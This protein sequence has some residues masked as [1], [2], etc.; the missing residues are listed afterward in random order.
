MS[1]VQFFGARARVSVT[2]AIVALASHPAVLFAE[3]HAHHEPDAGDLLFPAINFAIYAFI[4]VRY[5]IPAM[6][7]YLRRRGADVRQSVTEASAALT[8]AERE[9]AEAQRRL[10]TI[11]AEATSIR[12]DLVDAAT[13][14]GERL[15]AQ[16][17]ELG[18]RR[19]VDAAVLAEQERRRAMDEVRAETAALATKLAEERIRAALS[20]ADQRGFVERFLAEAASR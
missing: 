14:Y 4:I 3:E 16:A 20:P 2:V 11:A 8:T 10:A 9:A 13:A 19:V 12:Q 6:R 5:L 17:E 7:E 1:A 18:K 15:R